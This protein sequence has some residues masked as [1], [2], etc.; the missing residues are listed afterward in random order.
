MLRECGPAGSEAEARRQI[1]ETIRQV[2]QVLGNTPA[3]CRAC[4]VHPKILDM[5]AGGRLFNI[6]KQRT[7][8]ARAGLHADE[9]F[10]V[11][12]LRAS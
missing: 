11:A 4:Y 5:Y 3:I 6:S 10:M 12:A 2:A 1:V 7:G 9:A 8:A